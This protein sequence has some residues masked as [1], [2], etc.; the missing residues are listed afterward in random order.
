[1]LP[2]EHALPRRGH[3]MRLN[4]KKGE[5]HVPRSLVT[6]MVD[7]M[8][9]LGDATRCENYVARARKRLDAGLSWQK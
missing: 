4:L 8:H 3:Q 2:H 6:R 5:I 1:M 7:R 9:K